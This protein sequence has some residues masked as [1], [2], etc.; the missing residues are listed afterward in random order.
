MM[1][2]HGPLRVSELDLLDELYLRRVILIGD[3][4]RWPVREG[5]GL[6][7]GWLWTDWERYRLESHEP[8]CSH[9]IPQCRGSE[10]LLP[11][12]GRRRV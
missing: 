10:K 2:D 7:E 5:D 9:V 12:E 4:V 11:A 1:L 8:R 3:V 6:D